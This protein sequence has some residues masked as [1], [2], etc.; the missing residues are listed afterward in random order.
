MHDSVIHSLDELQHIQKSMAK[1]QNGEKNLDIKEKE[2]RFCMLC[3][4]D[5]WSICKVKYDEKCQK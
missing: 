2:R 3:F 4:F 5:L 1:K